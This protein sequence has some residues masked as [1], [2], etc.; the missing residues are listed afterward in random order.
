M[1]GVGWRGTDVGWQVFEDESLTI[2]WHRWRMIGCCKMNNF[3]LVLF[4]LFWCIFNVSTRTSATWGIADQYNIFIR[5]INIK[6]T[7]PVL[8]CPETFATCTT[9]VTRANDNSDFCFYL[10]AWPKYLKKI[11][12]HT[13]RIRKWLFQN[14]SNTWGLWYLRA[15]SYKNSH[16]CIVIC[17]FP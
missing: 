7:F 9:P 14:S 13:Y 1:S 11:K 6:S 10:N 17:Q 15:L 8:Q 16:N 5:F 2:G 4:H 3:D 12:V